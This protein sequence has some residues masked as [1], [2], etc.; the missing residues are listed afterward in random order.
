MALWIPLL[1]RESWYILDGCVVCAAMD[2]KYAGDDDSLLMSTLPLPRSKRVQHPSAQGAL[3]GLMAIG[4]DVV[5]DMRGTERAA[6]EGKLVAGC[7]VQS[8]TERACDDGGLVDFCSIL[9]SAK[10]MQC[11]KCNASIRKDF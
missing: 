8:F 9:T 4:I 10:D 1:T 7:V 11:S 3:A 5:R 6:V 2:G